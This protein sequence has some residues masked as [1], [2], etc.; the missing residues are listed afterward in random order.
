MIH[1]RKTFE[2]KNTV[3]SSLIK[4]MKNPSKNNIFESLEIKELK[5]INVY[6]LLFPLHSFQ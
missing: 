1:I 3:Y 2:L 6:Y 4:M 5:L